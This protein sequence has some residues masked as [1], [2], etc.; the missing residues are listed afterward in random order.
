MKKV[1]A[2]QARAI[3]RKAGAVE[4][5]V[6]KVSLTEA[7]KMGLAYWNE[8]LEIA[9]CIAENYPLDLVA[10]SERP[11]FEAARDRIAKSIRMQKSKRGS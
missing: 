6:P 4:I 10:P 1:T 8:A 3:W 2:K 5:K 7:E 9:A 11:F